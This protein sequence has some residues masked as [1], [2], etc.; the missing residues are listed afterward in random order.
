MKGVILAGGKGTRLA[1]L[2]NVTN[3]HLLPV[4]KEPM[5]W[6]SVKQLV[7]A[8]IHKI[9]VITS[10]EH[11]GDI[12]NCL[13][14]GYAFDCEFTF[15]VQE[16]AMG[17]ANALSLAESFA[18]TG[19]LTVLL[20]DNIFEYSIASYIDNYREQTE[21]ARILLT[22]VDEPEHFG[23]AA[24]DERHEIIN[25]EEKPRMPKSKYAVLGCYMYDA[26]VFDVIRTIKPS[27]RGEYEI[28]TVN[29]A[30]IQLGQLEYSII[31][32]AWADAG[33][34]ESYREANNLLYNNDNRILR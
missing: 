4:G 26:G 32:G 19:R 34:F 8:G 14:S 23:I 18:D 21:G 30:Y 5:I 1:P 16:H 33:T 15:K 7:S 9:L 29:Q 28:T 27:A 25:I 6:H 31:H 13:G 20:G 11:M 22:Q 2:T 24:L 10:T 17:I 3:K 12:I